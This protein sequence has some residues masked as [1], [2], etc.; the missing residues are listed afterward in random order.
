MELKQVS[1]NAE[2]RFEDLEFEDMQE[3]IRVSFLRN[4][5]FDLERQALQRIG[6]FELQKNA[7]TFLNT[8]EKA[9]RNK[10]NAL[11]DYGL[12]SLRSKVTKKPAFYVHRYSGIPLI[13]SNAFGLIDRNTNIIEVKPLTGCNENCIYCSVDE[14]LSTG[15][16]AEIVVEKDYLVEEFRKL[17]AVKE[18]EVEAYIN[19][20]GEPTLYGKLPGLIR[21]LKSIENVR[22]VVM[23]SNGSVLDE[24]YIDQLAEAGLKRLNLSLNAID[25]KK[26]KVVAGWG[27]YRIERI[28]KMAEH[29]AKKM[30]LLI[31]PVWLPGYNDEEI[32]KLIRYAMD[33][34]AKI[35]VQNYLY[36]KRGRNPATPM[37]WDKFY[38]K[39]A[40]LEK[41][42]GI[43][44]TKMDLKGEFRIMATKNLPKPFRKGQVIDARIM[45]PGRYPKE[46]I[47]VAVTGDKGDSG[48]E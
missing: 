8:T 48:K 35:G 20:Q 40:G 16:T 41:E 7:I 22:A 43:N 4:F 42:F 29:A 19:S 15:K 36:Y 10:F 31:A 12:A 21:G 2:L 6:D 3:T 46:K 26:A 37:E 24:E 32:P 1:G 5:Y 14:G 44:L 39:L 25:E 27:L 18:C 33:I 13:G 11:L 45:C 47:A 28:K 34:G 23:N 9:A 38:E 17:A 30:E